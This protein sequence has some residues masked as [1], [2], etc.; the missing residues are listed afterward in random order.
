MIRTSNLQNRVPIGP[1]VS[2]IDS[3]EIPWED[4]SLSEPAQ[5]VA[6]SCH[7]GVRLLDLAASVGLALFVTAGLAAAL[8]L[9]TGLTLS[10]PHLIS[11]CEGF[12]LW[13]LALFSV[14]TSA[15]S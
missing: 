5:R 10:S 14:V 1:R 3:G 11:A 6:P 13:S 2:P 9:Y 4:R 7:T 15:R 8:G 12:F